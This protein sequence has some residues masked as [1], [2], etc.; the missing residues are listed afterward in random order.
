MP[1]YALIDLKS[2]NADTNREATLQAKHVVLNNPLEF[3][4]PDHQ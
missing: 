3:R 1:I 4:N 2:I